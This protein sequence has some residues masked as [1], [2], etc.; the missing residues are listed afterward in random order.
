MNWLVVVRE[1]V[2]VEGGRGEEGEE[3]EGLMGRWRRRN[4][5]RDTGGREAAEIS[6]DEKKAKKLMK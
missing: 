2:E 6:L 5:D 3:G 1:E 4:V